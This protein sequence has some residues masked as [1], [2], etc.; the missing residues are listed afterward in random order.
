MD[1]SVQSDPVPLI[2]AAGGTFDM[3]PVFRAQFPRVARIIARV[4]NDTARAEELSV[5]VFLKLSRTPRVQAGNVNPWLYRTAIRVAL[6]ELRKH[7]RREKYERIFTLSRQA[8]I[9]SGE[10]VSDTARQ[11]RSILASIDKR[12]AEILMLQSEGFSYEEIALAIGIKRAS[13]GKVISRA[14]QLFRKEYVKRYGKP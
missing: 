9:E 2:A 10:T 13:I 8:T 6:D 11:V 4:V 7:A 12:S 1:M 5:E 3:D 14:Q